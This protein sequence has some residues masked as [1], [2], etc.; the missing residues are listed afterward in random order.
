MSS[1]IYWPV[2]LPVAVGSTIVG[3]IGLAVVRYSDVPGRPW[4]FIAFV[5]AALGALSCLILALLHARET[6]E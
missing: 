3:V 1:H 5:L 2:V 6:S 4:G